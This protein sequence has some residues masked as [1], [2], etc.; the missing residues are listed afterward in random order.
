MA[1]VRRQA[2][3]EGKVER[4]PFG[5]ARYKLQLS[6][7]DREEFTR[8]KMVPRWFNDQDGRIQKALGGGYNFVKPEYATSLGSG[9]IHQGNTDEGSR[10]SKVVSKGDPVIRA[11]L[12]EIKEK[13]WKADQALKEKRNQETDKAINIGADGGADPNQYGPGVTY[14]H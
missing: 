10:V 7:A 2:R 14:S 13:Y 8:R 9:A 12:M 1:N 4:V 5:A 6:D 3:Q 11:Y